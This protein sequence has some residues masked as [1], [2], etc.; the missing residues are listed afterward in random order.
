MNRGAGVKFSVVIP[1]RERSDT[2]A[3]TL[4]TCVGQNYKNLEIIVSDNYSQ[5][6]TRGV[7]ESFSDNRIRY[8]N[9]LKRVGMSQNWEHAFS[10]VTGDFVMFLG[11]D[12]GLLPGAISRIAEI[13]TR[14]EW[15]VFA[16]KPATYYWGQSA[17]AANRFKLVIPWGK[18][19][20]VE[21]AG[22]KILRDVLKRRQPYFELPMPYIRSFVRT[23]IL[24]KLKAR[25]G[26]LFCSRIPDVFLGVAVAN[27]AGDYGFSFEPYSIGGVSQHSTGASS[28]DPAATRKPEELFL[29]EDNL[30]FHPE[31]EYAP[32]TELVLWES[33]LQVRD[34]FGMPH[35]ILSCLDESE[36]LVW[37]VRQ[38]SRLPA[39][40]YALCMGIL[41]QIARK[42][43]L[44]R[45]FEGARIR[46]LNKEQSER[47][48]VNGYNI[49]HHQLVFDCSHIADRTVFGAS[50][51]CTN[52][53]EARNSN[54]FNL[55]NSA[56]IA[57][58][59]R[60]LS[61]KVRRLG[62]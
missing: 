14:V 59:I 53:I 57:T 37:C 45:E 16:W 48:E 11:D 38:A 39:Q 61:Q 54:L 40:R 50:Q 36:R 25:A 27:Q 1:T 20:P 28:L 60:L 6:N 32:L 49:R 56:L 46:F 2:L 3:A 43:N 30:D 23:Q 18:T 24:H 5:D 4:K 35:E 21:R 62:L 22:L 26:R 58:N 19:E 31:L 42:K 15:N 7:V 9:T 17:I 33:V 10:L 12:D 8:T 13:L 51:L 47:V 34:H 41:A 52:L 29:S 55:S 44:Q